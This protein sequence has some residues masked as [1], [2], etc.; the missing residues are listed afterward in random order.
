MRCG[1]RCTLESMRV[2]CSIAN[3]LERGGACAVARSAAAKVKLK[4]WWEQ[5]LRD[6]RCPSAFRKE[7][8][9]DG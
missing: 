1:S 5:S 3:V 6:Q 9:I 8:V 4:A 7:G 2:L